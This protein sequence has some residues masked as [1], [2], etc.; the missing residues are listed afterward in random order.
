MNQKLF[1]EK[2]L[3]LHQ[4]TIERFASGILKEALLYHSQAPGKLLRPIFAQKVCESLE[5][6]P[7]GAIPWAACCELLHNATLIH[8]DLQDGD[9]FRR[10]RPT[11]WK[12]FGANQAI[13]AGDFALICAPG[14]LTNKYTPQKV[15]ELHKI[16]IEM[17]S[18]IVDGQSLEFTLNTDLEAQDLKKNYLQCITQKTSLL[19]SKMMEGIAVIYDLNHAQRVE[20]VSL[21][22]RV[23]ILFQMQDD[24]LDLYGS[25]Q[26]DEVGCDIKEGKVSFLVANHL[27]NN[28][29]D[30]QT[31]KEIILKPREATTQEEVELVRDIFVSSGT[32]S[33]CLDELNQIV[34]SIT[35]NKLLDHQDMRLFVLET[36][37]K[38]LLP[39]RHLNQTYPRDCFNISL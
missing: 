2:A 36:I 22:D 32:L 31:I 26:R 20:L 15:I 37:V 25:K 1:L 14:I 38:V 21:F 17:A 23:G 8:D 16:F 11:V 19:F 5:L 27:S 7:E 24:I 34:I 6:D 28:H 12:K 29:E 10:G 9:S 4:E 30:K 13:N 18:G 39:I 35:R 3:E 33:L